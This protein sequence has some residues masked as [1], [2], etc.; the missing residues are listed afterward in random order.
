MRALPEH[1]SL[2]RYIRYYN[3]NG[4]G[5]IVME[6]VRGL[7]LSRI[8][9]RRGPLPPS[10]VIDL[11]LS[12]LHGLE[13]LHRHGFIHGDLHVDNVM[14]TSF[15]QA[16]IKII[17]FEHTVRKRSHGQA[18]A[19]RRLPRPPAKLPPE[20]RR[21]WID[22][23]YDIY[24]VGFMCACMLR[25]RVLVRRPARRPVRSERAAQLWQIVRKAI[26]RNPN[27]RYSSVQEMIEALHAIRAE[28]T[29]DLSP[30]SEAEPHFDLDAD[31]EM[32]LDSTRNRPLPHG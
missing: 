26:A 1:P 22:D 15:R 7:P 24:G 20:T 12:I 19:R 13:A 21:R 31:L 18:R 28:P 3:Q 17:D 9:R 32:N 27:G 5:H 23:R 4:K 6:R 30:P 2:V 14:V 10:K 8:I 25:G 29:D 16:T 11:A